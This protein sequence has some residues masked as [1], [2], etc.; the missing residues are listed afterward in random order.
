MKQKLLN[1][2]YI[3]LGNICIAFALS[4]LILENNIIAGGVSGIGI[5]MNYYFGISISMSV[6]LIN[7]V[8]FLLGLIFLGKAFAMSTLI[9][10]FLFPMILDVFEKTTFIHHYLNDP[11]LAC[12]IAG[13]L[14]GIGIGLILKTNASTGG[15]DIL[16]IL[17]N[18]KLNIP[19][20]IVLNVIDLIV[21]ILQF[22]FN[23][24]THVIYGIITVMI[25][26]LMLKRTLMA[27]TSLTQLLVMSDS[28]ESIREMILHEHDAG[29]TLLA[30]EKGY[31]QESSQ[32]I[33]SILP[34]RKLPIIKEK[35]L[36]IDDHAFIIVSH[37]DEV[38][39]QGFT[40]AK[41]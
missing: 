24:T 26:S 9:S 15:I 13:F 40:F 17:M 14:M 27:G 39:G 5:V 31:T 36:K 18:K 6:A 3:F 41:R 7:I 20:H 28:Y 33:L 29:V 10:T 11:L 1:I 25:T 22:S 37:V 35:I 23:D 19:V 32:L 34:Y 12:V 16:A 21:L 38:G 4:T 30:G 8:L 2:G